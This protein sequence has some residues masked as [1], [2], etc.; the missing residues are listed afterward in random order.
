MAI[1]LQNKHNIKTQNKKAKALQVVNSQCK[2]IVHPKAGRLMTLKKGAEYLGVSLWALRSL[3][4]EG[5]LA[6]V[7]FGE[8]KQLVDVTDLDTLIDS[9]KV[10]II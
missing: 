5:K 6:V 2:R 1:P 3:V 8:R 10:F 4:W 9:H 7:K